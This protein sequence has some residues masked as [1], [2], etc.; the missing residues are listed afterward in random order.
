MNLSSKKS[1]SLLFTFLI[2]TSPLATAQGMSC[3]DVGDL[4]FHC[5]TPFDN[6]QYMRCCIGGHA[7]NFFDWL[8][9][10]SI[11]LAVT[12]VSSI[13]VY[14]IMQT[15]PA[16]TLGMKIV[17]ALVAVSSYL[18]VFVTSGCLTV[19]NHCCSSSCCTESILPRFRA[20][21]QNFEFCPKTLTQAVVPLPAPSAPAN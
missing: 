5:R 6:P 11:Y 18:W 7:W 20:Q 21:I 17:S 16:R 15:A 1:I 3:A 13:L 10:S 19:K 9:S 4:D 14:G 8:S 2:F 12:I